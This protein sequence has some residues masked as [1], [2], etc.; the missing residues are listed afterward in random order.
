M[1]TPGKDDLQHVRF[2]PIMIAIF[3]GS[4]VSILSMSTINIAIPMLSEHFHSDLSII[5]WT[6]TGFMLASGTIAPITGYLGEKFS[7]KRLYA[8]ALIGFTVFSLLCALAWD[9]SSL[10]VFRI[11]QGAFS[12]LIMPATMTIVYQ[13]IPRE[14]QPIAISL[15]SLAAMMAPAIGPTLSGWLL[16]NWSWH[17]LFLMNIPVGVI[18]VILV[19][20]LIPYYRLAVPKKF[21]SI[22]LITV[23]ISSLSLLVGFS[24]G[25]A[26]G[27]TSARILGLF[28]FGVVVL[29]LFI[30]R[31]LS[32]ESPL[33]NLRVMKNT[34]FSLSLLISSIVTI[35]L[36]SGTFL[37]PIFLQN[38]QHVTPLD[39]GLILLPAS[40]VMALSMPIVGKLYS[41]V[42]PRV[43]IF[44]GI[45][46]I[47]V[48]T[49]TLSWLSTDVSRSYILFWMIVRNLGIAC[50]MM[51]SS[52]A[53][54]EQIPRTMT[55][56]AT[57]IN[58]WV[59]NVFGSLAIALFTSVLSSQTVT[60][61]KELAL[62]GM[63]D[64]I[65]LGSHAF[66][67][68]VNDVYLLATF[69]VLAALPLSL[70]IRKNTSTPNKPSTASEPAVTAPRAS[71]A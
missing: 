67:M 48:G 1:S 39:T 45:T 26:W 30:W 42:G 59:R 36:Y 29:L 23:V 53:A 33:L 57:S 28:A 31:E 5:Q 9:S 11:I 49:L 32:V 41:I 35:S 20:R 13:V 51:P 40:L 43:L 19:L 44:T 68:G 46:L 63:K 37:T 18:A 8:L 4:F 52:N 6:I 12:G 61:S 62:G 47:A 2:W 27:W 21:D 10:I 71:K 50:A 64:K 15:W 55:G 24:Q 56:H 14:K 3:F 7:Y 16:Q 22:G 69:I 58:N 34:R 17:W 66:T 38:I 25:H 60:H 54:M 65:Q 70:F